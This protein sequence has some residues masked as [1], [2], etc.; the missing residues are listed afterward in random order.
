MF[1]YVHSGIVLSLSNESY[2]F[3]DR[4][5]AGWYGFLI[6]PE[7]IPNKYEFAKAVIK[8]YNQYLSGEIYGYDIGETNCWGFYDKNEMIEEVKCN[9]DYFLGKKEKRNS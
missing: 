4:F 8:K 6:V 5:D 1:A 9:I 7:D 2:P 3:N